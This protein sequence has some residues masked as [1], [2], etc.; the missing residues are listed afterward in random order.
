MAMVTTGEGEGNEIAATG[1]VRSHHRRAIGV[2][3]QE[4]E[5]DSEKKSCVRILEC[6]IDMLF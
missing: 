6:G 5:E 2:R 3:R 1:V 4:D